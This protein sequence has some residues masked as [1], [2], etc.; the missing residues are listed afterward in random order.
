MSWPNKA[1]RE[2]YE[3]AGFITAYFRLCGLAY[4]VEAKREKPDYWL[5]CPEAEPLGVELTS[6]Y[7]D[8]RSV[9]DRHM[10]TKQLS[11]IPDD[12]ETISRYLRRLAEAVRDK[13]RK[14]AAGYDRTRRLVLSV[15]VNEYES[16]Y[17]EPTDLAAMMRAHSE[18][19]RFTALFSEVVFWNLQDGEAYRVRLEEFAEQTVAADR[20][21]DAAPAEPQR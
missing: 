13:A 16:I 11:H 2:Q 19:F 10:V 18:C 6:V 14:A 9:P 7:L 12:P 17:L 20:R 1:A 15:Y 8:D 21:E 4:A 5:T 3:I